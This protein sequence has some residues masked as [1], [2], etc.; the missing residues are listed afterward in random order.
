MIRAEVGCLRN[1]PRDIKIK[2]YCYV[3]SCHW[4]RDENEVQYLHSFTKSEE[5]WLGW[6]TSS[7]AT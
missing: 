5:I 3:W 4:I 2:I 1:R 7:S 6:E